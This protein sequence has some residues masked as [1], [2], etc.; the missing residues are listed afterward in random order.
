[1]AGAQPTRQ[2]GSA[3][4]VPWLEG[5]KPIWSSTIVRVSGQKRKAQRG[6]MPPW[7]CP[8]TEICRPAREYIVRIALTTYS[9]ATWMSPMQLPGSSTEHQ[10]MPS[11]VEG[12]LPVPGEVMRAD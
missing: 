2:S 4:I 7:L 3:P 8:M 1:M 10:G 5:A 12:G 9:P 6:T 11:F